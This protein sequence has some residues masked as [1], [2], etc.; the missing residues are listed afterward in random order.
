MTAWCAI[1]DSFTYLNDHLDETGHFVT[2]GYLTRINDKLP[3]LSLTNIGINGGFM[4][5]GLGEIVFTAVVITCLGGSLAL[6]I[7]PP[8]RKKYLA[9]K[10][11]KTSE[12]E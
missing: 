7:T 12:T 4:K 8:I 3:A 1:G 9:K 10:A 6:L 5:S 2:R 11:G